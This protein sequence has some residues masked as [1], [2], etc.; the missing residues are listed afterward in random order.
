MQKYIRCQWISWKW[1]SSLNMKRS[2]I[3]WK[4]NTQ[5]KLIVPE[6]VGHKWVSARSKYFRKKKKF[7]TVETAA[8]SNKKW[9]NSKTCLD[10]HWTD[11]LLNINQNGIQTYGKFE[12]LALIHLVLTVYLFHLLSTAPLILQHLWYKLPLLHSVPRIVALISAR[13]IVL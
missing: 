1:M 2:A 11:F 7:F 9:E 10:F 6:I 13:A 8:T 4:S 5:G 3:L 12:L